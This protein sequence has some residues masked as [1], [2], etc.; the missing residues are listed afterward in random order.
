MNQICCKH[1][2]YYDKIAHQFK[3]SPVTG[4]PVIDHLIN[5]TELSRVCV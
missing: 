3:Q 1:G 5:H 4:H 2:G